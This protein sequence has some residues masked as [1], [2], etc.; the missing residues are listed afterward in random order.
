MHSTH[1]DGT[2]GGGERRAGASA[3]A[4]AADGRATA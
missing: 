4:A 3:R 2:R 1:T